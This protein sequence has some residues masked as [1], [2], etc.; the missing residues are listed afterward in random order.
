MPAE[1]NEKLSLDVS[2][3]RKASLVD[4]F[5][6]VIERLERLNDAHLLASAVHQAIGETLI[7]SS[8]AEKESDIA[9]EPILTPKRLREVVAPYLDAVAKVQETIDSA[10]GRKPDVF[11]VHLISQ[12]SPISASVSGIAEAVRLLQETVVPWRREHAEM[13]A[14]LLEQEKIVEIEMRKAEIRE[15]RAASEKDLAEAVRQ[16]EE[17]ERIRLENEKLR[18]ELQRAKIDLALEIMK[19]VA[20]DLPETDRISFV[21]KLLPSL[22]TLIT[23]ELTISSFEGL[24]PSAELP[25]R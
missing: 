16:R 3:P 8:E 11:M 13:M 20:P 6:S 7:L 10:R 21:L 1:E 17:V 12:L 19:R 2:Q 23:N 14:H 4:D 24:P 15:R 5:K 18:L 9:E 25:A 22:E